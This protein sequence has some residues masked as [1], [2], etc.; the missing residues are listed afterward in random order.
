MFQVDK[1]RYPKDLNEL[2]TE[3]YIPEI[4]DAPYGSKIVYDSNN[5]SVRVV[6]E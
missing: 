1:G 6:K 2:V 4:P 3:K 5:G